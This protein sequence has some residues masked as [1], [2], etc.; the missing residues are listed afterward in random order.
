[1]V[2]QDQMPQGPGGV[3]G[4]GPQ[5]QP[6]NF[7]QWMQYQEMLRRQQ[8]FD[9]MRW[10]QMPGNQQPYGGNHIANWMW[11]QF[12]TA[13]PNMIGDWYKRQ[14]YYDM[15]NASRKDK[16]W[17]DNFL[18]KQHLDSMAFKGD[19]LDMLRGVF[20]PGGTLSGLGD[21]MATAMGGLTNLPWFQ[22]VDKSQSQSDAKGTAVVDTGIS[23]QG[24]INKPHNRRIGR[25]LQGRRAKGGSG[26]AIA[27]AL[28][29]SIR[30][31]Q[32]PQGLK[33]AKQLFN[34]NV[35]DR[36]KGNIEALGSMMKG[37]K[38]ASSNELKALDTKRKLH[39]A[40]TAAGPKMAQ[41]YG[42]MLQDI[43]GGFGG[44]FGGG[45]GG[46]NI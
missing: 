2:M 35:G 14:Q 42:N 7:Q 25:A 21:A 30:G 41:M 24:M 3:W 15:W 22:N 8:Y 12:N 17:M 9:Y 20:Q 1:M 36:A 29:D 16:I 18:M 6:L 34:R 32:T 11:N 4:H 44:I 39:S 31:T 23:K 5:G 45:G 40:R 38:D 33:I 37:Y 28:F 27:N 26:G 46:F 13:L 10:M 43:L 19:L